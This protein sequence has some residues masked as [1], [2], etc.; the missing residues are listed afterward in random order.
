MGIQ[1]ILEYLKLWDILQ[2]VQLGEEPDTISWRW[3]SSGSYSAC[4]AYRLF[5][6]GRTSLEHKPIW[7]SLAPPRCRY[8]LW[9]VALNRCWTADC[10]RSRGPSHP[11]RCPLCDQCDEMIDHLLV[12]CSESR[13]LWWIAL[14]AIGHSECLPLNVHSFHSW[15]CDSRKRM[16]KEHRRG[17]DTIA[18]LVAWTI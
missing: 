8:F 14:S 15:L 7:K 6:A 17:F 12:A 10:L 3:E 5:F 16:A 1:A 9:L 18:T 13:Q 4:S 2:S 11:A